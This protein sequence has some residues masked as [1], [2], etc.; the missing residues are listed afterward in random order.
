MYKPANIV[1]GVGLEPRSGSSGFILKSASY[2]SKFIAKI[3]L[4][5][6]LTIQ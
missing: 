5:N 6:I 3:C 2:N 4:D 1:Q